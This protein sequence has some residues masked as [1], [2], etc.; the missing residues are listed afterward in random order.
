M[1]ICRTVQA[2]LYAVSYLAMAELIFQHIKGVI[3]Y[4]AWGE[5]QVFF[6]F[7]IY[8]LHSG[9]NSRLVQVDALIVL[10]HNMLDTVFHLEQQ[11]RLLQ[12]SP[13]RC[14]CTDCHLE[15]NIVV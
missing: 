7:L 14:F 6:N 8:I 15:T 4:T 12:M 13:L 2:Y 9:F 5:C 10:V 3:K 11:R 1:P